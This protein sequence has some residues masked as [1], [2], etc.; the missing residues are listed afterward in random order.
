MNKELL[1]LV[2][3][4][5]AP[6]QMLKEEWFKEFCENFASVILSEAEAECEQE[7]QLL[8]AQKEVKSCTIN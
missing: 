1:K 2:K 7:L 4:A 6:K 8:L 5:H 3:A